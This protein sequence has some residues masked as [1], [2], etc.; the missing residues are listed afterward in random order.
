[1]P[2]VCAITGKKTRFLKTSTRRGS[3]KRKGGV[4]LKQTGVHQRSQKPNLQKKTLWVGGT[5]RRVWLST[6]ALRT[7]DQ[8]LLP[9]PPR[10]RRGS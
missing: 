6:A 5:P 3:A 8:T 9:P 10:G 7:L 1:M 4:G 2:R